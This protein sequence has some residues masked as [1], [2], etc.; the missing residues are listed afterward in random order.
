M[1][2]FRTTWFANISV[3]SLCLAAGALAQPQTND[4]LELAIA[5][6]SAPLP[7]R[8][9]K[10]SELQEAA[11]EQHEASLKAEPP[12]PSPASETW[13]VTRGGANSAVVSVVTT[14]SVGTVVDGLNP[15]LAPD[16]EIDPLLR[17][18]ARIRLSGDFNARFRNTPLHLAVRAVAEH[19]GM[20]YVSGATDDMASPVTINGAYNP[21]DLLDLLQTHY[22]VALNFERGT[23][24]ISRSRPDSLVYIS[25]R[26]Y[27]NSREEVEIS[28]PSIQSSLGGD[29]GVGGAGVGGDSGSGGGS[30]KVSYN[31]LTKDISELLSV[32]NPETNGA[33]DTV[34]GGK[35]TFIPETN[36]VLVLASNYHHSLV[37]DYI[38]KIDQPVE[39]IEFTAYFVESTRSPSRNLGID[40]TTAI[41]STVSGQSPANDLNFIV[42]RATILNKYQFAAALKFTESDSQSWVAQQPTVVGMPHRKTVLDATEQIPVAQS[43][44]SNNVASTSTTTSQLE[45]LDVG[46]IVNIYPVPITAQDGSRVLRMHVSLVVSSITGERIISGNPAPITSRRRFEFSVEVPDGQTLVIGG[47]VSSSSTR[48]S[49][50]VPILG[51]VPL[52]G[53]AFRSDNDTVSRTNMTAFITPHILSK[54][55]PRNIA[56]PRV[57][58]E[59][60]SYNR[61][62]FD[63]DGADFAQLRASLDGFGREIAALETYNL[64]NRDPMVINERLRG[65]QDEL[66]AMK[67][68]VRRLRR[69]GLVIDSL[70]S[71]TISA[72]S[73]RATM[74]RLKIFSEMKI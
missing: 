54:T 55:A 44:T 6:A 68:C 10:V 43:S 28:S 1:T 19:A 27:N 41:S 12:Q 25:Y 13:P 60:L 47:L 23:W 42:P 22:G 31:R 17:E 24:R 59:D 16:V 3:L 40:W 11:I 21:L 49:T 34:A 72:H 62:V 57:W 52:V 8:E 50:K 53:R 2:S 33:K 74:L 65:L 36:E 39:G 14:E 26:L 35:V 51:N 18:R 30:F 4:S 70:I 5:Q 58:P 64:Q 71:D 63:S 9:I 73:S 7:P 32:P 48:S 61:P 38:R 29:S 15:P 37:K 67:K 56:L 46:T 45:Y 66:A 69:E 20:R